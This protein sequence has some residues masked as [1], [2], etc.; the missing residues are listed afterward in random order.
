MTLA[1][2]YN[3]HHSFAQRIIGRRQRTVAS[4]VAILRCYDGLL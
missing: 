4:L 3:G 1:D 2:D